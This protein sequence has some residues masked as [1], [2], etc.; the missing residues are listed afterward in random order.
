MRVT[1]HNHHRSILLRASDDFLSALGSNELIVAGPASDLPGTDVI[2]VTPEG[3]VLA[4]K[5]EDE[6]ETTGAG[7]PTLIVLYPVE[8]EYDLSLIDSYISQA[9]E[10]ER[11]VVVLLPEDPREEAV[12]SSVAGTPP[13][14]PDSA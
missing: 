7:P 8:D 5:P 2:I 14:R 3:T 10:A 1:I 12:P 4:E 6:I 9:A 11:D 13:P